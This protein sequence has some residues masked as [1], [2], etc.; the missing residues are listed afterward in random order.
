MRVTSR[1]VTAANV[2]TKTHS[3]SMVHKHKHQR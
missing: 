1:D 2:H 3:L